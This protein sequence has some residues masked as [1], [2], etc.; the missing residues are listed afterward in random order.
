MELPKTFLR[1][2]ALYEAHGFHLYLVGGSSRDLLLGKVPA[3]LD[4]ATDATP[5]EEKAF[6]PN[7]ID[8]YASF[9]SIQVKEEGQTIDITTFREEGDYKDHRHPGFVRF[10][11]DPLLDSVRRDFTINALYI[12]KEGK[13]LDFHEGRNDLEG[14]TIRFIG[15][16]KKRIEE[17]PLRILRAYRFAKRLGFKI[18]EGTLNALKENEG[19]LETLNPEKVKME[20]N[21]E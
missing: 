21:K 14:K 13:I 7:C 6:L 10:V 16:P 19:L 20:R 4:F 3:D 2:A 17:D 12:D 15:D 5:E 8:R 18:E 1:Y 9:G 11:R